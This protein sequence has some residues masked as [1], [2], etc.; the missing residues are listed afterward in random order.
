VGLRFVS[1]TS[2]AI[3]SIDGLAAVHDG[4][5]QHLSEQRAASRAFSS[6][7]HYNRIDLWS[8]DKYFKRRVSNIFADGKLHIRSSRL[9]GELGHT[10]I[11]EVGRLCNPSW[12]MNRV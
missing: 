8:M 12:R 7:Q 9:A 10:T 2:A 6:M 5:K 11:E 1:L 4:Q 3:L